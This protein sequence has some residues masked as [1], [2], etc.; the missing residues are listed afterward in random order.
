MTM[1]YFIAAYC[2]LSLSSSASAQLGKEISGSKLLTTSIRTGDT[3]VFIFDPV[4]ADA[5]NVTWR[6]PPRSAIPFGCPM[7]NRWSLRQIAKMKKHLTCISPMRTGHKSG[8]LLM[9]RAA[10][11]TISPVFRRTG[12]EFGL[13]WPRRIRP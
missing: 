2:V 8:N 5:F 13:V 6:H 9:R 12:E 10:Q 3:E 7:A 4:T 11:F 1:R